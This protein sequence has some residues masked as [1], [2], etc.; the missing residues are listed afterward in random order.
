MRRATGRH[1]LAADAEHLLP[2][3]AATKPKDVFADPFASAES[4]PRPA[5]VVL[6]DGTEDASLRERRG[7]LL[8]AADRAGVSVHTVRATDSAGWSGV[9]RYAALLAR[10]GWTAAYLA[11]GRGHTAQA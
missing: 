10:G 11:V 7:R 8:S 5:L 9:A 2:L 1:A 4:A 6:D 3:I